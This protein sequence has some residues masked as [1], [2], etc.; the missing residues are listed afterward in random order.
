MKKVLDLFN[1]VKILVDEE[2]IKQKKLLEE[3]ETAITKIES[4]RML[5]NM[6]NF[7]EREKNLLKKEINLKLY[8]LLELVTV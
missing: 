4:K 2:N 5:T 6:E 7:I 3:I 8:L 1:K